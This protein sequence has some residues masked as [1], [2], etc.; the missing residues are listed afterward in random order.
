MGS[1]RSGFCRAGQIDPSAESVAKPIRPDE[2][3]EEKKGKE[4]EEVPVQIQAVGED[5]SEE[6]PVVK[7]ARIATD[8]AY[9]AVREA[10]EEEE[11]ADKREKVAP[12]EKGGLEP[13]EEGRGA[14]PMHGRNKST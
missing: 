8:E 10:M 9:E 1:P 4:S 2:E 11:K 12:K 6:D 5:D 14:K 13:E 7:K 3:N